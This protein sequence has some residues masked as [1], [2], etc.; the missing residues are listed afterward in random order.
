[1]NIWVGKQELNGIDLLS[2]AGAFRSSG[3]IK[4]KSIAC[5][6]Q[7]SHRSPVRRHTLSRYLPHGVDGTLEKSGD[8]K[9]L[10][11]V[12]LSVKAEKLVRDV[13]TYAVLGLVDLVSH[14][15]LGGGGTGV[16]SGVAILGNVLVGLL[17]SGVGGTL[18]GVRDRL[19]SV[20]EDV[21][22]S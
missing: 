7:S 6:L 3:R 11:L 2:Y 4:Q 20:A 1:M 10:G 9:H 21:L 14:S 19:G 15:V 22:V 12:C 17:G 18:D 16:E 8:A 13:R 5:R